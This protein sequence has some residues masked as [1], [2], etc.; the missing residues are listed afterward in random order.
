MATRCQFGVTSNSG[1]IPHLLTIRFS[2]SPDTFIMAA[3]SVT[4]Y[5]L[6]CYHRPVFLV[7][8]MLPT[9][10]CVQW[11]LLIPGLENTIYPSAWISS[12]FFRE[13]FILL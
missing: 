1:L 7:V 10:V 12:S 8:G 4:F 3:D 5:S 6:V 2:K 9:L 13:G 11:V